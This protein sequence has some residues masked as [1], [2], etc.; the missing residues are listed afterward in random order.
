MLATA[1][2]NPI[3]RRQTRRRLKVWGGAALHS[4]AAQYTAG[5][6]ASAHMRPR[7]GALQILDSSPVPRSMLCCLYVPFKLP[8]VCGPLVS[9][10]DPGLSRK[11]TRVGGMSGQ[12]RG[13]RPGGLAAQYSIAGCS[14]VVFRLPRADLRDDTDLQVILQQITSSDPS[15]RKSFV[16][17]CDGDLRSL[18]V[19]LRS[20]EQ[21]NSTHAYCTVFR[22]SDSGDRRLFPG[23]HLRAKVGP[24]VQ[25]R[26]YTCS[27]LWKSAGTNM[28][29][30][31]VCRCRPK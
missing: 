22:K 4:Q 14:C 5:Q 2:D 15:R 27:Q 6:R 16:Q 24:G 26:V 17:S 13:M 11:F 21:S 3:L 20:G 12:L 28:Q 29:N 19:H 9:E 23:R 8:F 1:A 25:S 7:C 10:P 18:K 30:F 31:T